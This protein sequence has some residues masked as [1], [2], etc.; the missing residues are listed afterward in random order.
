MM[1][2]VSLHLTDLQSFTICVLH[3]TK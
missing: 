3:N 1:V 2:T